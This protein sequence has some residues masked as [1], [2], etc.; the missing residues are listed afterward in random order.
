MRLLACVTDPFSR[1]LIY[2]GRWANPSQTSARRINTAQVWRSSA[3]KGQ[4][5][6]FFP[7]R[8][9]QKI[10][11]NSSNLWVFFCFFYTLRQTWEQASPFQY[12]TDDR[13][14]TFLLTRKLAAT[15]RP[16]VKLS[17]VLASKLRYPLI[18]KEKEEPLIKRCKIKQSTRQG[19]GYIGSCS[20]GNG[21][22]TAALVTNHISAQV[23]IKYLEQTQFWGRQVLSEIRKVILLEE[24]WRQC[25]RQ[26]SSQHRHKLKKEK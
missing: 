14:L 22:D 23:H 13:N 26:R 1:I 20:G 17:M 2:K 7:L 11:N 5:C 19:T 25:K 8:N 6:P 21:E 9:F 18:C 15:A 4:I 10:G 12:K 24:K 16:C 3:T